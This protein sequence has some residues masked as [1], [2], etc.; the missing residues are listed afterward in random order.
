MAGDC[1]QAHLQQVFRP[2]DIDFQRYLV[3][4]V[5]QQNLDD[6]EAVRSGAA[7]TYASR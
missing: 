4:S 5:Q 7:C 6:T 1:A 2:N 3:R